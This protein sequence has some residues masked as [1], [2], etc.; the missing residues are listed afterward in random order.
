MLYWQLFFMAIYW[1]FPLSS[2]G[3]EVQGEFW[4]REAK[5]GEDFWQPPVSWES[6]HWRQC[7]EER[8]RELLR[9]EPAGSLPPAPA[10]WNA[11]EQALW[12]EYWTLC[13]EQAQ[14]HR[15]ARS[16]APQERALRQQAW[17]QNRGARQAALRQ[18][19]RET[20]ALDQQQEN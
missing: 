15:Q 8:R 16:L 7:V 18:W 13:R 12:S 14:G 9:P 1:A 6:R 4:P 10:G 2:P 19:V 17:E 20:L 5:R 11:A 3:H